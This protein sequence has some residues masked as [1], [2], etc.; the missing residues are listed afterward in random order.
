M[1]YYLEIFYKSGSNERVIANFGDKEPS[2][3]AA[4]AGLRQASN[5]TFIAYDIDETGK[6]WNKDL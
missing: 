5:I 1:E 3:G 6:R 2:R 4:M